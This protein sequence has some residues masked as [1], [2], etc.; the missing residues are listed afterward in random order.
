MAGYTVGIA[1]ETKAFKQ[2]IESGVIDPL[3]DAQKELLELGKSRGPEQLERAMKDAERA[4]ER[5]QDETKDTARAIEQ[6]FR[7]AYRSVKRSSD[8]G[9]DGAKQ[10]L[11]D[12]KEESRQTARESAA[13]FDGSAESIVDAFQ[14][15]AANA[16]GGFGLAGQLAGVAAALGIGAAVVGF[17]KV[18][19]AEQASREAAAEW[20][21]AYVEAGSRILSA[22]QIVESA[23]DIITDADQYQKAK[24]NA[25]DWGV[26]ESI[27]L[28]A[29]AG[30]TNALAQAREGL[31]EKEAEVSAALEK[32]G[33]DLRGLNYETRTMREEVSAGTESLDALTGQMSAGWQ[34]AD[35]LSEAL[36]LVAQNTKDAT[37]TVDEF[38]DTVY[39][40]PGGKQ[41]YIDAETGQATENVT[42]I[43]Q[44]IYGIPDGSSTV[45]VTADTSAVDN[46]IR[47][48]SG[49]TL[50]IGTKFVTSGAEWD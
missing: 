40:L 31:A 2:G 15:I 23:R 4:T 39:T 5:L 27:A 17:E 18:S 16:F 36:R 19:E 48:L 46:E 21:D 44:K 41:I 29:M 30:D 26:T 35:V 37:S 38:G 28:L 24:D 7:D 20:A 34:Q 45:T 22:T 11:D 13:S 3:E 9:I 33:G 32:A 42:A 25:K 10:G 50:R 47:R 14:E 8:D 12:F 1:S 43:E 49:T 6:E